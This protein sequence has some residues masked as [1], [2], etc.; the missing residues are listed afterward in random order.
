MPSPTSSTWPVS[1]TS[2][3][4]PKSAI[5]R[6][7]ITAISPGDCLSVAMGATRHQVGAEGLEPGADRGVVDLV[8]DPD[9]QAAE[10]VR[11]DAGVEHR[12]GLQGPGQGLRQGGGLVV[13]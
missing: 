9:D 8:A 12:L 7:R 13:G 6:S 2:V 5:C 1:R 3:L 11:V 4:N 10:Q